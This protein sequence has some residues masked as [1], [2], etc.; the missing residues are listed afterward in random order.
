MVLLSFLSD[1]EDDACGGFDDDDDM[2]SCW[3]SSEEWFRLVLLPDV[4]VGNI[5]DLVDED[6]IDSL[7]V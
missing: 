7:R 2:L 4:V 5:A 3:S 6:D 1:E